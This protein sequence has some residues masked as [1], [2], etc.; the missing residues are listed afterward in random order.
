MIRTRYDNVQR[1][2][3]KEEGRKDAG[4]AFVA[5]AGGSEK[6]SGKRHTPRGA[7]GRGVGGKGEVGAEV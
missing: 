1:Q 6:F 7:G 4:H 3:N 5:G 2:R